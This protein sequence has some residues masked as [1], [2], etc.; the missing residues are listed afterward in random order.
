M[1]FQFDV[2]QDFVDC[3]T[4]VFAD[5]KSI[6]QELFR[7]SKALLCV[8]EQHALRTHFNGEHERARVRF[9]VIQFEVV[10]HLVGNRE[11]FLKVLMAIPHLFEKGNGCIQPTLCCLDLKCAVVGK[12]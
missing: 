4:L 1:A 6:V 7:L 2:P 5:K 8:F 12:G 9:N 10:I 11:T 3:R